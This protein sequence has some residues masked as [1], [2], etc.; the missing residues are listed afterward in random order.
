MKKKKKSRETKTNTATEHLILSRWGGKG[1]Y[2]A[3]TLTWDSLA[4]L[5][6]TTSLSRCRTMAS[7]ANHSDMMRS[8]SVRTVS[9]KVARS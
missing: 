2:A 8:Y 1:R 7:T 6:A 3:G 5:A 9:S 4:R